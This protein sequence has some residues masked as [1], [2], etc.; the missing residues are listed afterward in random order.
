MIEPLNASLL[1][2][3]LQRLVRAQDAIAVMPDPMPDMSVGTTGVDPMSAAAIVDMQQEISALL[4][5]ATDA[6]LVMAY[7]EI[8]GEP[9]GRE[10]EAVFAEIERRNLQI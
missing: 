4:A 9:A 10:S 6:D 5:E 1:Q 2:A 7:Q 3:E 8:A